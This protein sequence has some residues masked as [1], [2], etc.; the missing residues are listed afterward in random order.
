ML[1]S[2][3]ASL[4]ILC[5]SL[6]FAGEAV[7]GVPGLQERLDKLAAAKDGGPQTVSIPRGT[8][9][10]YWDKAL[11]QVHYF[12][13]SSPD[14]PKLVGISF[15]NLTDVTFD[16]QDSLFIFHGKMTPVV[17]KNC[18][19]CTLKNFRVDFD[20]PTICQVIVKENTAQGLTVEVSPEHSFEV[21]NGALVFFGDNWRHTPVS[22]IAFD[23][24]TRHLIYNSSDIGVNFSGVKQLGG[25]TFLCPNWKDARLVPGTAVATRQ[26]AMPDA[27]L[28]IQSC[29]DT[30]LQNIKYHFAEGKALVAQVSRNIHLDNFSVCLRE[31][32]YQGGPNAR[33]FTA[34]ADATHF[35]GCKGLLLVE[36]GLYESMMDDA[37]NVHGTYLK[38]VRRID[39]TTLEGRYMH[40][41]TGG[42]HW[43]D[44]GDKVSF[45][46]SRTM[47]YDDRENVIETIGPVDQPTEDGA[48]VFR[49]RFKDPLPAEISEKGAYGIENLT[50]TPEVIF[51]KN[52]IRN[53][54]ARGAL[55]ST[56]KKTL[57]EKNLFD[58]TS[59]AAI[60]LCGD[61][62]GWFETGACRE[63]VIRENTFINA[64]TCYFQYTSAIISIQ[65]EI[66][67]FKAQK[68]FFHGGKPDAILIENNTFQTFDRPIVYAKSA[69]GLTIRNNAVKKNN[70][71]KPFHWNRHSFLFHHVV[72]HTIE[73]N[74]FDGPFDLN[75]DVKVDCANAG[76]NVQ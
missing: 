56:P 62:N 51:R 15:Q 32:D 22:A 75:K 19:N 17:M 37:I 11:R 25:R 68:K 16:G 28:F 69:D 64:L 8:Y 30:K 13:N 2:F 42:F 45:V 21:E 65:P 60:L 53:N 5:S 36:N 9:H 67:D 59:G 70:D 23:G 73:N 71:F 12:S 14:N 46:N 4:F 52:V 74:T 26:G 10:F 24:K 58:H 54:R 6:A 61:C 50:W 41:A 31:Q 57:V 39:G 49:I 66:P 55:F 44:P 48:R 72:N 7:H 76:S 27:G 47:E 1:K 43:G 29:T 40:R 63:V 20:K 38:V 3:V 18:I 34:N 35:S 33:Y